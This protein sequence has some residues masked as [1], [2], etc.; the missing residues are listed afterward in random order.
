MN[1]ATTDL[2]DEPC[3]GRDHLIMKCGIRRG[4]SLSFLLE[5]N[6]P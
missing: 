1:L 5:E 3:F 4:I 6:R 2:P